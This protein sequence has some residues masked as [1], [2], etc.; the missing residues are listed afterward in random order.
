MLSLLSR[1]ALVPFTTTSK[2]VRSSRLPG[3][4][5]SACR[6]TTTSGAAALHEALVHEVYVPAS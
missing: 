5:A 4:E 3:G 6:C 1:N 2:I